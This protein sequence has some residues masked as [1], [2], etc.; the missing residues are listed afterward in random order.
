MSDQIQ[1]SDCTGTKFTVDSS[2]LTGSRILAQDGKFGIKVCTTDADF[3][4]LGFTQLDSVLLIQDT[5]KRYYDEKAPS[6]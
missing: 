6:S 5:L 4:L 2:K 3:I 1:L